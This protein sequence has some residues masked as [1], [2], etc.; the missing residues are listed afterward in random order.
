MDDPSL[1]QLRALVDVEQKANARER[2]RSSR[3][4]RAAAWQALDRLTRYV[5]T[6]RPPGQLP[7]DLVKAGG[8]ELTDAGR[9]L[10][11]GAWDVVTAVDR[12][13]GTMAD[14]VG[15]PTKVEISC[16]PAQAILVNQATKRLGLED[17]PIRVDLLEIEDS[18]RADSGR[19]AN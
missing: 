11:A 12:F 16:Y 7:V 9:I 18:F 13:K 1:L 14:V 17:P 4:D 15:Q 8:V 10:E 19:S 5:N 6:E 2:A 3:S